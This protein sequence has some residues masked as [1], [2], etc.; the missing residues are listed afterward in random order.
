[1]VIQPGMM[2]RDYRI[3]S[4]LG[5]G[6][7]GEVWLAED[8]NVN[9][10]LALKILYPQ[11]LKDNS[12][13]ERF[14]QEARLMANLQHP[15][16][17]SLHGMF[18]H[19]DTYVICME[20]VPGTSLKNLISMIGPV[21]FP[22]TLNILTQILEVL[23][24]IHA[25]GVVHRDIKPSNIMIDVTHND[26]IK[27]MDF[28]IAKAVADHTG[29]RTGSQLGTLY[30]MSPEQIQDSSKVD[31][32]TDIYSLGIT[33]F[34]MLSGRVPF[35]EDTS[36]DYQI[37]KKII[38]SVLPNPKSF[39]PY[40]PDWILPILN[41]MCQKS[42]AERYQEVD[43]IF[44][45]LKAGQA[46]PVMPEP[47][48]PIPEVIPPTLIP[49]KQQSSGSSRSTLMIILG[50]LIG[51]IAVGLIISFSVNRKATKAGTEASVDSP[52][53]GEELPGNLLRIEGGSFQMGSNSSRFPDE[54]PVH[55]VSVST[56]YLG[57]YEVTLAEWQE[58]L[59]SNPSNHTNANA[60]VTG[61]NWNDAI[62]YCNMRSIKENLSPCYTV[63]GSTS[64]SQWTD[65]S[66]VSC[67]LSANGYR[68]PTEAEWEYAARGGSNQSNTNYSGSN[69]INEVG[70]CL[71]P[72]LDDVHPD[73]YYD[74]KPYP[75]GSKQ[76]NNEGLY[77]MSGN[78]WEWC[79]D[80]YGEKFYSNS[81]AQ[82][83]QCTANGGKRILRGGSYDSVDGF[84]T[85]SLRGCKPPA[86]RHR[87]YGFR[88][89][90]TKA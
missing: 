19:E 26:A 8:V 51:L 90:R 53:A 64:P 30:Y 1:M 79:W 56:F 71:A 17:A 40:I 65:F 61:V 59:G 76:P 33:L 62:T 20:Y 16:I 73:K 89:C 83:P 72:G 27:L 85:V 74:L 63:N 13:A 70:Y 58:V 9:R 55:T 88:L 3:V 14:R 52:G 78:A 86:L 28:G 37:Q 34:E 75:V 18:Q 60:P 39:Y 32:R 87:T 11:L 21:P 23:K 4:L 22:R 35:L 46:Q 67:D 38:E 29:T 44:R 82:D 81:P 12:L 66:S 42:P 6:G 31:K 57:K 45:D 84:C 77:D 5:E 10:N 48:N 80:Y 49:P 24:Y 15:G 54:R 69:D 2:I 41:K 47:V 68:L 43:A 25:Q 36:S 50:V 7:M